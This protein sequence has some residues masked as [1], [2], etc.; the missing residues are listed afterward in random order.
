[1]SAMGMP[2]NHINAEM[3]TTFLF[4]HLPSLNN[5]STSATAFI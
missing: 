5:P 4:P 3:S 2:L 1:M